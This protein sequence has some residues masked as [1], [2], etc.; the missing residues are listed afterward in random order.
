M[1][2][3]TDEM[4]MAQARGGVLGGVNFTA[5]GPTKHKRDLDAE[6]RKRR[7]ARNALLAVSLNRTA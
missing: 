2:E 1:K 6:M 3:D 7:L 4:M 5:G